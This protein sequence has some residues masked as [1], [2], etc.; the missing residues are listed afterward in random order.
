M[1]ASWLSLKFASTHKATGRDDRQ[2]LNPDRRVGS[3][4][5]A[6]VADD[7]VDRRPDFRIGE[8][9]RRQVALRHRLIQSGP[10]LL[11]LRI[12]DIETALGGFQPA[13]A[14]RAAASAFS[15]SASA[16]WKR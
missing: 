13:R 6:A 5:S 12:D 11:F 2:E 10:D 15:W 1:C 14:L 3:R 16:C 9:E 8:V 4:A 7:S